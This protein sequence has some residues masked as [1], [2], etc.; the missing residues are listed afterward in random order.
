MTAQEILTSISLGISLYLL[1]AHY[2]HVKAVSDFNKRQ[3]EIND[4]IA[5][6]INRINEV[7]KK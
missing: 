5:R 3:L 1:G 4:T 2:F 7:L 6:I